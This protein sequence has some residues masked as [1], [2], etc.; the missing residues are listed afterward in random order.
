[1]NPVIG[2]QYMDDISEKLSRGT[3]IQIAWAGD[4]NLND[5]TKHHYS[6]LQINS[7]VLEYLQSNQFS[8][9]HDP[10]VTGNHVHSMLR[11]ISFDWTNPMQTHHLY[12]HIR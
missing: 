2:N 10:S 11:D 3:Y 4:K 8:V 12:S 7:I 1:M 6:Y 5:L 9:Q